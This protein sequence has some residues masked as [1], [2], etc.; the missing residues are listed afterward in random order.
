V[1]ATRPDADA[2]EATQVGC[3]RRWLRAGRAD[4]L[5]RV[6]I[7]QYLVEL[8]DAH[9][10]R[11][12]SD[13]AFQ[14][15][16]DE[17]QTWQVLADI[18]ADPL[19]ASTHRSAFI[20]A[21]LQRLIDHGAPLA[22]DSPQAE[23]LGAFLVA[24]CDGDAHALARLLETLVEEVAL[25]GDV[26]LAGALRDLGEPARVQRWL[27]AAGT[28]FTALGGGVRERSD[29]ATPAL[30]LRVGAALATQIDAA[31][32]QRWSAALS[33]RLGV[34]LPALV[35]PPPQA[36]LSSHQRSGD[37]PVPADARGYELELHLHGRLL[38][39]SRFYP[40]RVRTLSRDWDG[41]AAPEAIAC[42]DEG[43]WEPV[44][45]VD[46]GALDALGWRHPRQSFDEA[47]FDWLQQLLRR[48]VAGVFGPDDLIG[49]L[50][51]VAQRAGS[52]R[53]PVR[54]LQALASVLRGAHL[55]FARLVRERAP[56][57]ERSIELLMRLLE[58]VQEGDALDVALALPRLREHVRD[59][60]CRGFADDANRLSVLLLERADE[61]WLESRLQVTR[62]GLQRR[63]QLKPQEALQLAAAVRERFEDVARSDHAAPVIVCEDHLRAPLFDVLQ[64]F[65]PRLFVLS[66]SE[67]SP[68]VRLT[69]RGLVRRFAPTAEAA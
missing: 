14:A 69:S 25:L 12:L 67:L 5:S 65:D 2:D 9:A 34:P 38:G 54:E 66:Y 64:A 43:P 42:F 40:G 50:R 68:D 20:A 11:L 59:E 45:W 4:A 32:L 35:L 18:L 30:E 15:T 8:R 26:R 53:V 55:V 60:L 17:D 52:S 57:A 27:G 51:D 56:L 44:R 1:V 28:V 10:N 62:A 49:H 7:L 37:T 39:L 6:R 61:A 24:T 41:A 3:C 63:F 23:R 13:L 29:R 47:V 33:A 58:L 22:I 19:V 36:E 16:D 48:H 46:A 21:A 31:T